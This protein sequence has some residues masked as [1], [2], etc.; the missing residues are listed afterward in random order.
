MNVSFRSK[1]WRERILSNLAATPF[2][3]HINGETFECKSVEGF[4]QG[5]KCKDEMR[6][7]VFQLSGLAAKNTGKGKSAKHFYIAGNDIRVGS[8][9]HYELIREAIKQKILQNSKA[10]QALQESQGGITHSI[11]KK[12]DPIFK[13]E[14]MLTSIRKELFG[15]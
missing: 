1:D 3:I 13:M 6:K 14:R 2:T 10:A 9:E 4:W 5:L 8:K 11:P 15:H 12:G 7:H